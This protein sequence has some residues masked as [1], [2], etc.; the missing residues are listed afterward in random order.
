MKFKENDVVSLVKPVQAMN[1]GSGVEMELSPPMEGTVV[2]VH[3]AVD[4]PVA[5]EVEFYL[6]QADSYFLA[7]IETKEGALAPKQK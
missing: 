3:G 5:Y 6:P 4:N 1:L 2:L 7:T